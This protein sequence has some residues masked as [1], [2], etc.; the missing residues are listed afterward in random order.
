MYTRCASYSIRVRRQVEDVARIE[1]EF[2]FR[3][4]AAEDLQRRVRNEARVVRATD[5][6]TPLAAC[7]QQEHVVA[8]EVRPDTTAVA[9]PRDHEVIEPGIGHEGKQTQ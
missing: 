7:L 1:H 8:V 4:E 6:P 3:Y 2:L 9:G 5:A